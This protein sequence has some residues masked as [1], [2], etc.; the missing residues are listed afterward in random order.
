M[1]RFILYI[2]ERKEI[3]ELSDLE[4]KSWYNK[5]EG[6][7]KTNLDEE[8]IHGIY[9]S[10]ENDKTQLT[11]NFSK[12]LTKA[13][14]H[15]C[16]ILFNTFKPLRNFPDLLEKLISSNLGYKFFGY[17]IA[18]NNPENL[19]LLLSYFKDHKKDKTQ[20]AKDNQ[21]QKTGNPNLGSY[22]SKAAQE[23]KRKSYLDYD[24]GM[25][26]SLAAKLKASSKSLA[27]IAGE[28]TKNNFTTS[29]NNH[30]TAKGV[31]RLLEEYKI[32]N[33]SFDRSV[34]IRKCKEIELD[35]R[36]QKNLLLIEIKNNSNN[37]PVKL[38]LYDKNKLVGK[39]D[40]SSNRI[41]WNITKETQASL[42][43]P[44]TLK[45]FI[46]DFLPYINTQLFFNK[47][48][49]KPL[50]VEIKEES[51]IDKLNISIKNNN[52]NLPVKIEIFD[53]KGTPK[54]DET[55][56]VNEFELDLVK[57]TKALPGLLI[58]YILVE[59]FEPYKNDNI[60]FREIFLAK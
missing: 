2:I 9:H 3:S 33:E 12:C 22:A 36:P 6:K 40:I 51:V 35:V 39:K 55:F 4:R 13:K 29:R 52:K 23:R 24:K 18:V 21:K 42:S 19:S 56:L 50:E 58:V 11:D 53:N 26:R 8:D 48:I 31:Q 17:G 28:L 34:L 57:D 41:T 49:D 30:Y 5:E 25:A 46:E 38:E 43:T 44:L 54:G 32:I 10:Q 59:G 37:L 15:S 60:K 14:D 1:E 47:N 16:Q 20:K 45:I 7:L 27:N